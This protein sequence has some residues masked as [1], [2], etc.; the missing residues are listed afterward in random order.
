MARRDR[1]DPTE[2][3]DVSV[4]CSRATARHK[5]RRGEPLGVAA[6]RIMGI[7]EAWA[8]PQRLEPTDMLSK[9]DVVGLE[10]A[11]E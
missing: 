3:R 11:S 10:V 5:N 1:V 4:A 8:I 2:K 7:C 9:T 6:G